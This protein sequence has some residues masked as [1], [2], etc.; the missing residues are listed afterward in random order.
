MLVYTG[1]AWMHGMGRLLEGLSGR[2]TALCSFAL[3]ALDSFL[4]LL[5]LCVCVCVCVVVY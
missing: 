3:L 1:R 2:L 4:H 5:L